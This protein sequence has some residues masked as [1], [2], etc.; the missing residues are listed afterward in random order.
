MLNRAD[1]RQKMAE[2]FSNYDTAFTIQPYNFTRY[3]IGFSSNPTI[4]NITFNSVNITANLDNYG[5]IY[6]VAV[7][8]AD[9]LGKPTPFQISRGTDYRN[10][11]L[12]SGSVAI[13]VKFVVVDF[14]VPDL[15]P[16]TDY[17]LYMTAGSAH[18]GYP[19]LMTDSRTLFLEFK[20]PKAPI[21]PRLSLDFGPIFMLS[22]TA[23]GFLIIGHFL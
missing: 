23:F 4:V 9:D 13:D 7:R 2:V 12:P 6:A 17:N 15:D 5:F 14:L 20:T 11:P 10:V 18:P 16:D 8:K 3:E 1:K 19:D 21:I 22:W